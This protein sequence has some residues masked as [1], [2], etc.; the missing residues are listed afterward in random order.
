MAK[1]NICGVYKITNKVNGK[2]Y[3]GSSKDI[4]KRWKHHVY[5]LN[6]GKHVNSY[7]QN[8]WNK[9]GEDSFIFDIQEVCDENHIREREQYYID[10]YNCCNREIGYNIVPKVDMSEMSAETKE[11]ISKAS[12][13]KH[14]GENMGL[15]KYSEDKII[16]V[17]ADL[18]DVNYTYKEIAN[19]YNIPIQ[20]IISIA[21]KNTWN[22][23]T[24]DV[25]FPKR[26]SSRQSS[27]ITEED[28]FNIINMIFDNKTNLEIANE[29]G[30]SINIIVSIRTKQAWTDYT[31]NYNFPKSPKHGTT[32]GEKN[33]FSKLKETDVKEIRRML[34]VNEKV[35][36]IA[37]KFNVNTQTIYDIKNMKT[38]KNVLV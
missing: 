22:Y 38:W 19:K 24:K 25:E 35:S 13:G 33:Y 3:I 26:I 34:K 8:A 2:I 10:V 12:M 36:T 9:Y 6:S 18:M 5:R 30:I 15:N 28:L 17:I 7:L 11:K 20:T 16:Q 29:L 4:Y 14:I 1:E 21:N 32:I 27:N 31:K 37:K 23:L